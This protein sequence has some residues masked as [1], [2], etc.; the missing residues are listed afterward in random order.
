M[1]KEGQ[2][3]L[4]IR[5]KMLSMLA[6]REYSRIEMEQKISVWL[7]KRKTQIAE[8]SIDNEDVDVL[9]KILDEFE[10]KGWISDERYAESLLNQKA[11]RLGVGRLKHEL[12][13]K[14]VCASLMQNALAELAQTEL[15]RAYQIWQR[16]FME[17]PNSPAAYQKQMRFLVYRGFSVDTVKKILVEFDADEV[18]DN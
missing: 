11:H 14:G 13:V 7:N 15:S 1:N 12:K 10:A 9:P 3:K 8:K 17:L 6:K 4:S 5:T 16:K 18:F 2:N